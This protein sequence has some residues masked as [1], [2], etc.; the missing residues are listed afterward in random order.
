[1]N[2]EWWE[3]PACIICDYWWVI[4]IILVVG[5]GVYFTRDLWMPLLG[6]F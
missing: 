4:L 3:Q 5:L 6:M 2:K 1:M